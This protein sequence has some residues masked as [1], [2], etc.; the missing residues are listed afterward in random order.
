MSWYV[1]A[2]GRPL[3]VLE[4]V[5]GRLERP[6]MAEPENSIKNNILK[7]IELGLLSYPPSNPVEVVASG[8]QHFVGEGIINHFEVKFSAITNWVE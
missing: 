3:K 1:S 7:S 6:D 8:T 4:F 2:K 5:R